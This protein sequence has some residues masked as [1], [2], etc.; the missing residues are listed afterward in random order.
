MGY[1]IGSRVG[2]Y[3][4]LQVLGAGGMGRVYKVRNVLS[5]R[6]EAMKV[7]LPDLAGNPELADRFMREIKVQAS[8]DHPNIAA[9]HTALRVENQL[10]M[11]MEYVEGIT[12]DKVMES[13]PVPIDKANGYI[14]QVLSALSYA[15]ARGVIHRD[16]KPGNMMITPSGE[17]KLMDFGIAKMTAD[18]KLTQTGSTVGSL[19]YMSPEQIKGSLDLD[20]RSDLYSLG[21]S[22]Y[23]VVTG[24]RPFQGDS[25]Y[26]IMAAHLEKNPPPPIQISPN[27]PSG[28]N[29]VILQALEKDPARRFQTADAF[30]AALLYACN[31]AQS[32]APAAPAA[33]KAKAQPVIPPPP[34]STQSAGSHRGLWIG[35]GALVVVA[36]LV[37]AA[38]QLPKFRQTAAETAPAA[39]PAAVAESA[40]E[41]SETA[42]PAQ[43]EEA[44][45][46]APSSSLQADTPQPPPP[47]STPVRSAGS[48]FT[49]AQTRP[50]VRSAAATPAAASPQSPVAFQASTERAPS[51][52]VQ[53]PA[54][55]AAPAE[56]PRIAQQ[57][58]EVREQL[59]LL[60]IR[61]D[62]VKDSLNRLRQQQAAS[63]LGLRGDM[64]SAAQRMEYLY[65]QS[66]TALNRRDIEGAKKNLDLAEREVSKL[67]TF[68]GR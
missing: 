39:E 14:A 2:D 36:I 60:G 37:V 59:N 63:G 41:S 34:P 54:P 61:M 30:R 35:I 7:L 3:E 22:L 16:L 46:Q 42:A 50:A 20:P 56:D 6:V 17:V 38:M 64:A 33:V 12:L 25:E 18:R 24:A 55:P 43:P 48:G 44:T 66:E 23:E 65:S 52:P 62:T 47:A 11:L 58:N 29:E 5:D 57:L 51:A 9:L 13:G 4:I 8:L 10:L 27:L 21:V 40:P 68:L 28:L 31:S 15:H 32:A 53:A 49:A 26:S 1:E 45:L 19:Y 67:E